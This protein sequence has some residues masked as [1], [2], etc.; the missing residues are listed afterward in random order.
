MRPLFACMPMVLAASAVLGGCGGGLAEGESQFERGDYPG[1]KRT[2]ERLEGASHE[3]PD[4]QRAKYAL[5]RGLTLWAL[6]DRDRASD[7]LK[8]ARDAERARPGSLSA[9]ERSRLSVVVEAIGG[10]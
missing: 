1:A 3:Y 8:Q 5:Y 7:W 4:S 9:D 6:G 2:F 10:P